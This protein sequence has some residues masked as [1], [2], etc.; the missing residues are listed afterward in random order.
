MYISIMSS[1]RD[2]I[3]DA[4]RRLLAEGGP[5]ALTMDALATASGLSRATVYRRIGSR[6]ALIARLTEEGLDVGERGDLS[7]RIL[8]AAARTFGRLGF[9][10]TVEQI[11]EQAG[12]GSATIYRHFGDKESLI[13]ALASTRGGRGMMRGL[14]EQ[15]TGDLRADL[16]RITRELMRTMRVDGDLMRLA[17]I[18]VP[19]HPGLRERM[20]AAPDRLSRSLVAFFARAVARGQLPPRDPEALAYTFVGPL[21]MQVLLR[22]TFLDGPLPDPET[23]APQH[24]S[25][26]LSGA[27]SAEEAPCSDR[28]DQTR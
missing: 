4:A 6:E 28:V 1:Q 8:D 5:D 13:L 21:L 15:L 9:E 10:A 26:F 20:R 27:L 23:F 14:E 16:T 24:V 25:L 19:R 12:V 11:A 3:L 18:E 17:I 22:G 2:P 7:E